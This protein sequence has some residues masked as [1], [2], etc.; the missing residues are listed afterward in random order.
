MESIELEHKE[1]LEVKQ[2][3]QFTQST[4]S[5]QEELNK[6]IEIISPSLKVLVQRHV[7]SDV[8]KAN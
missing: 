1:Q 8:L 3:F 4:L 7:F 6:F 5:Q 2:Y